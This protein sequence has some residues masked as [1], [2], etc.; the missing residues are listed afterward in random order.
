MDFMVTRS[1]DTGPKLVLDERVEE[2]AREWW[3]DLQT[4]RG[5]RRDATDKQEKNEMSGFEQLPPGTT[6]LREWIWKLNFGTNAKVLGSNLAVAK[7]GI[8]A[9]NKFYKTDTEF[10][11]FEQDAMAD[12][13]NA[14]YISVTP[15]GAS[16]TQGA[17]DYFTSNL[18]KPVSWETPRTISAGA[19]WDGVEIDAA[20]DGGDAH[21]QVGQLFKMYQPDKPVYVRFDFSDVGGGS[22]AVSWYGENVD[23]EGHITDIGEVFDDA[24]DGTEFRFKRVDNDQLGAGVS[25]RRNRAVATPSV[26]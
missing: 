1:G 7:E 10:W 26:G 24:I 20:G 5:V 12:L 15:S 2:A 14:Q 25:I 23:S 4:R 11:K 9:D 6:D 3:E 18:A 17:L 22:L 19:A 21:E 13:A 16:W 8:G